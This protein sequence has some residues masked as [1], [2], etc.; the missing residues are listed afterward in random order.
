MRTVRSGAELGRALRDVAKYTKED[1]SKVLRKLALDA[2]RELVLRSAIDT[3]YLRSN[4]DVV[5]NVAAPNEKKKNPG[6][7]HP[8][9]TPPA[10]VNVQAGSIIVLYN[11]TEY[12]IHLE[13]GTPKM[14]AQ[15]MVQPTYEMLLT[16]FRGRNTMFKD[17]IA[18]IEKRLAAQWTDTA[19][20]YDNVNFKPTLGT[21][22]V[23]V[24]VE[25]VS[26]DRV[27]IGGRVRGSG[28]I[29]LSIFAPVN[30]GVQD[31]NK[32][33]DDLAAIF[34]GYHSDG[35]VCNVSRTVRV[36]QQEEWYQLKVIT[37]FIFDQCL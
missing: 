13:H 34:D 32:I 8:A 17:A 14:R 31:V 16:S 33:A 26:T 30:K 12:A 24:Q 11:N 9:A 22:F 36:G 21:S 3:G 27:S 37:P 35:L 29:D 2:F 23:R 25:W 5:V 20:D 28:Y 6:G 19:I 18:L 4:W 7:N 10:L 15:P 1:F